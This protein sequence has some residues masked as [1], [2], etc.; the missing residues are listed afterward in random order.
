MT[1][2]FERHGI[3]RLSASSLNM[4]RA[5]TA[6]WLISYGYDVKQTANLPMMAGS[7]VEHAV[8]YGI[9]NP[10]ASIEACNEKASKDWGRRTALGG[11][12]DVDRKSKLDD[13]IGYGS[14]R[15]SYP[16]MVEN[17]VKELRQYGVPTECQIKVETQLDGIP[18]P[19]IGYKDFSYD[20][21]GLD[22]D[23]KTTS[24]MPTDMSADHQLQGAIYWKASGNRTQRFCYSTKSEAKVLELEPHAAEAAIAE[25]TQIAHILMRLLSVSNDIGEIVGL[26]IPDF[27]NFRWSPPTRAKAEE[28]WAAANQKQPPAMV[29]V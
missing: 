25:A 28:V 10:D 15:R 6:A 18:V 4:A 26:V 24:R 14:A 20:A 1:N 13:I 2:A 21:H 12:R 22:V 11:F 23:L 5:N 16:G 17:A 9:C 19:I 29:S 8:E 27:S 7:V 3:H